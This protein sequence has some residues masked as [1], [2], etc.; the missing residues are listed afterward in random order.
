M[1]VGLKVLLVVVTLQRWGDL[2]R[3][4]GVLSQ[5]PGTSHQKRWGPTTAI[6]PQSGTRYTLNADTNLQEGARL[7]RLLHQ[8]LRPLQHGVD[9]LHLQPNGSRFHVSGA[10]Y[11]QLNI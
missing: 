4:R 3:E 11:K 8:Q 5:Y 2:G 7:L 9:G 6:A 10:K 1:R